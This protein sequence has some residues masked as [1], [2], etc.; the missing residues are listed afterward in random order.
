ML[1]EP[2]QVTGLGEDG[3]GVDRANAEDLLQA[4][5]VGMAAQ[6]PPLNALGQP[7]L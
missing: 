1:P 6:C 3:Q 2:A 7:G 4:A 5:V